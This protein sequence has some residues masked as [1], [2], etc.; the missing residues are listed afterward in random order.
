MNFFDVSIVPAISLVE[1]FWFS[2]GDEGGFAGAI[3]GCYVCGGVDWVCDEFF[4]PLE[5]DGV[6]V[7]VVDISGAD[8]SEEDVWG[9]VLQYVEL[10]WVSWASNLLSSQLTIGTLRISPYP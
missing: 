7:C 6:E 2:V 3:D 1:A 8:E 9:D 5:E 10:R 4:G